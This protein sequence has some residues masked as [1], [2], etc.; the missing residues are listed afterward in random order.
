M[1]DVH[2]LCVLGRMLCTCVCV[3]KGTATLRETRSTGIPMLWSE[4]LLSGPDR[5]SCFNGICRYVVYLLLSSGVFL[6]CSAVGCAA[7][8]DSAILR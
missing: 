7:S 1:G 4:M 5:T 6:N 8:V 3:L 2:V